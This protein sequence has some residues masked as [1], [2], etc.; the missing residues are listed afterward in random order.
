MTI[1]FRVIAPCLLAMF[2]SGAAS[3]QRILVETVSRSSMGEATRAS[4]HGVDLERMAGLPRSVVLPMPNPLGDIMRSSD[5][6]AAYVI[7]GPPWRGEEVLSLQPPAFLSVTATSTLQPATRVPTALP[8]GWRPTAALLLSDDAL[9]VSSKRHSPE[10]QWEGRLDVYERERLGERVGSAPKATYELPGPAVAMLA[11]PNGRVALLCDAS[12]G[13]GA[14][15]HVRDVST[16]AVAVETLRI[17][18]VETARVPILCLYEARVVIG[19]RTRHVGIPRKKTS[20]RRYCY[21]SEDSSV[22]S[23]PHNRSHI[24]ALLLSGL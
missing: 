20:D 9:A 7:S 23:V 16:G 2:W 8:Q 3:A 15:L 6:D 13:L 1:I 18:A 21:S 5:G 11:L 19:N 4:L 17:S 12:R 14:A 10:G 24:S 22:S